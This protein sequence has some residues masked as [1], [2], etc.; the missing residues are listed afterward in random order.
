MVDVS[1][2]S[3]TNSN[4]SLLAAPTQQTSSSPSSSEVPQSNPQTSVVAPNFNTLG[5]HSSDS[6]FLCFEGLLPDW[7]TCRVWFYSMAVSFHFVWINRMF[8]TLMNKAPLIWLDMKSNEDACTL[9]GFLTHRT[10]PDNSLV[11]S[12]FITEATFNKVAQNATHSWTWPPS[13]QA[14]I[15]D[16]P[17]EGPGLSSTPLEHRLTSP[18][19]STPTPD[20]SLLHRAAMTLEERVKPPRHSRGGLKHR[21]RKAKQQQKA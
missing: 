2:S 16:D 21:K 5:N 7:E 8:G 18:G 1:L 10:M 3:S 20:V 15:I 11:I 19:P 6:R 4:P 9:Q 17:M 14:A 13:A 12:H